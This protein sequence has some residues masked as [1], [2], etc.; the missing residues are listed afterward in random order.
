MSSHLVTTPPARSY[1]NEGNPS[2]LKLQPTTKDPA[3]VLGDELMV[4]IFSR[5]DISSLVASRQVCRNWNRI[6]GDASLWKNFIYRE[7]AFSNSDWARC[8]GPEVVAHED[9]TEEW[10]SLPWREYIKDSRKFQDLFPGCSY[11]SKM[12]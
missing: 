2:H 9:C 6:A 7:I 8:F 5:L 4:D 12:S 10:A 11:K 3:S 1:P